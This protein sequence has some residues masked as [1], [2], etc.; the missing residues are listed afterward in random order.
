MSAVVQPEAGVCAQ[1]SAE[2]ADTAG[3]AHW[4]KHSGMA[5]VSAA[6]GRRARTIATRPQLI[7]DWKAALNRFTIQFEGRIP[8]L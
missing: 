5:E 8:P 7:R 6:A 4:A 1:G 3:R 2:A